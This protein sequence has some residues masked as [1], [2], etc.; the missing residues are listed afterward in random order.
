MYFSAMARALWPAVKVVNS[1]GCLDEDNSKL[2]L[3]YE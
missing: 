2:G 1:G 3:Y